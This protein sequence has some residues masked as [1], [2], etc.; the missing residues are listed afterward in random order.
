MSLVIARYHDPY[1]CGAC[2]R[3]DKLGRYEL[4]IHTNGRTVFRGSYVS[5]NSARSAMNRFSDIWTLEK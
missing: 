1:G 3:I 2:I 5:R 4:I